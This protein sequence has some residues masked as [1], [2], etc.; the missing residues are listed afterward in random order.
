[1]LPEEFEYYLVDVDFHDNNV[2]LILNII[3]GNSP[4]LF[5]GGSIDSRIMC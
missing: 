5:S 4:C 2:V 3:K 1:M